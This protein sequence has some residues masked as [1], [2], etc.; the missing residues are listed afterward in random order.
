M[1]VGGIALHQGMR[2]AWRILQSADNG[3]GPEFSSDAKLLGQPRS[4]SMCREAQ[5]VL[6]RKRTMWEACVSLGTEQQG[7]KADLVAYGMIALGVATSIL[8]VLALGWVAS[9]VFPPLALA[10]LALF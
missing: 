7:R 10:I 9:L 2:A 4:K 1:G 8:W 6:V 3:H 5:R